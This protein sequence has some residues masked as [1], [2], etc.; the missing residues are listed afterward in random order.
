MSEPVCGDIVVS[1]VI[2]H[3]V[4]QDGHITLHDHQ[5]GTGWNKEDSI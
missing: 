5:A 2:C 3:G 1:G 4:I